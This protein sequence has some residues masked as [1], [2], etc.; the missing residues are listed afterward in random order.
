MIREFNRTLIMKGYDWDLEHNHED[1]HVFASSI[2][3][4]KRKI[5]N[6]V[7]AVVQSIPD[8]PIV[9]IHIPTMETTIDDEMGED[10]VELF[11]LLAGLNRE[12]L[13]IVES[14]TA[15]LKAREILGFNHPGRRPT[16]ESQIKN[17]GNPHVN[18][19]GIG[20]SLY[21]EI[22]TPKLRKPSIGNRDCRSLQRCEIVAQNLEGWYGWKVKPI[23]LLEQ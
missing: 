10:T 12:L 6:E 15:H 17:H 20:S 1:I 22:P 11:N 16:I 21:F 2:L 18:R 14:R 7:F 5:N 23:Y 8:N 19:T 4:P 3:I 13:N 9:R